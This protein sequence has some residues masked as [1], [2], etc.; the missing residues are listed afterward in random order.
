MIHKKTK[1]WVDLFPKNDKKGLVP[2]TI[3]GAVYLAESIENQVTYLTKDILRRNTHNLP[4]RVKWM[5]K[6]RDLYSY[7]NLNKNLLNISDREINQALNVKPTS[8][9]RDKISTMRQ[10]FKSK[11][12]TPNGLSA[13]P[14]KFYFR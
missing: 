4:V 13:Q 9:F 7:S 3:E 10:L 8:K 14:V 1:K 11:T 6:L 2:I 12:A 5:H